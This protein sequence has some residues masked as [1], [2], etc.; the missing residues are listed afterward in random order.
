MA[1]ELVLDTALNVN[2]IDTVTK[3]LDVGN[4]DMVGFH[5]KEASGN[6]AGTV[7]RMY[8]SPDNTNWFKTSILSAT[9]VNLINTAETFDTRGTQFIR[10]QV[11]TASGVAATED[12]TII[13]S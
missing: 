5:M 1:K 4:I 3:S 12:T 7:W 9:Q 8:C 13:V 10:F 11:D 2:S 6:H